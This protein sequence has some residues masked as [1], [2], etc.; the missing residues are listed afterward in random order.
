MPEYIFVINPGSTSTKTAL[1]LRD[2]CLFERSISHATEVLASFAAIADQLPMRLDAVETALSDAIIASGLSGPQ[3][4]MA[5]VG[6][7]GLIHPVQSGIFLINETMLADLTSARFGEHASNLGALI[8]SAFGERFHRPAFIVDPVTVDEFDPVARMTG[9][10]E[11]KRRST[12]HALN[13]KAVARMAA[14][15]LGTTYESMYL[16]V[17][18]LGGG[19]SIGAHALGRVIDVNDALNEGP[20]SPERAGSL[21]SLALIDLAFSGQYDKASLRRRVN[22]QGGLVALTG[23]SDCRQIEEQAAFRPEYAAAL[24]AMI[25]QTVKWIGAMAV[26]LGG[27]AQAI[28]L[29]GGLARS[30]Y[31]T[32]RIRDRVA[33]LAPVMIFPGEAELAALAAGALRVLDGDAQLGIY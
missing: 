33:F 12:F 19:I 9:L 4:I 32:S 5:F 15:Q 25:Y 23:T 11:I 1:F 27:K 6:R 13:Q 28:V 29:T 16:V 26:V 21:P 10:P 14:S 17:A 24:D 30:E 18:H 3:D 20:L 31:L 8:A 22:G 2:Q 7:G